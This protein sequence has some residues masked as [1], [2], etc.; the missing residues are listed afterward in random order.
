MIQCL[1][2][3]ARDWAVAAWTADRHLTSSYEDFLHQFQ[4]VFDHLDQRQSSSQQFNNGLNFA[5][6]M[7]LACRDE[8]KDLKSL[9]ALA[10]SLDQHLRGKAGELLPL[11]F[12]VY[13]PASLVSSLS[14]PSIAAH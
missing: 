9:I 2:G 7:E 4:A 13:S 6:P 8:G 12:S 10:I 1:S 14:M 5:I 11:R 3:Q